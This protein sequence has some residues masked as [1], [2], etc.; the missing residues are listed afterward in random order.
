M[1]KLTPWLLLGGRVRIA[2]LTA[3]L[4]QEQL[5]VETGMSRPTISY[6][7]HGYIDIRMSQLYAIA[8]ATRRYPSYF[9]PE[10]QE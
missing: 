3:S 9:I 6:I 2:R 5:A 8:T 7:E 1:T 10:M 4:T